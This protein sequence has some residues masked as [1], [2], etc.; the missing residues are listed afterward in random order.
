M[1]GKRNMGVRRITK[2]LGAIV[3]HIRRE[4]GNFEP[5]RCRGCRFVIPPIGIPLEVLEPLETEPCE[6]EV[7]RFTDLGLTPDLCVPPGIY[8]GII[9]PGIFLGKPTHHFLVIAG[10]EMHGTPAV[11]VRMA[12][13]SI[14]WRA[15][16]R[17]SLRS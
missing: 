16:R 3:T 11:A 17:A 14:D 1:G 6:D 8:S 15:V 4:F 9:A 13:G 7:H 2:D 5:C 10:S 12:T